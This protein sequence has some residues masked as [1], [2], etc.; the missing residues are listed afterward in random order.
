MDGA[1]HERDKLIIRLVLE[2][3]AREEGIANIH[4]S[5]L[6]ERD[7]RFYF[8][9]IT[10]KTGSMSAI[11]S[12]LAD[13]TSTV[14]LKRRQGRA[15]P[16][17]HAKGPDGSGSAGTVFRSPGESACLRR[18]KNMKT[19]ARKQPIAD[20]ASEFL[21]NKRIAVTGVSRTAAGHGSN[22]VY[23]RLRQRGYE[24]SRSIRTPPQSRVTSPT[25][26]SEQSPAVSRRW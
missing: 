23:Q 22:V 6:I 5:D 9:R 13:S 16:W 11:R 3:G 14:A 18:W 8:V 26:A 25:R 15:R 1:E 19:V 12:L 20:A 10:D 21:A 4:T 17:S 7:R 24:V 2:T